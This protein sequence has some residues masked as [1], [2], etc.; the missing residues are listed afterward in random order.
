MGLKGC[1]PEVLRAVFLY[2]V[3]KEGGKDSVQFSLYPCA[4]DPVTFDVT[5]TGKLSGQQVPFCVCTRV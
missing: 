1:E 4:L 5:L 3:G 2:A